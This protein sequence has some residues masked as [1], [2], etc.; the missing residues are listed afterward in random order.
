MN[1]FLVSG[2]LEQLCVVPGVI[3]ASN[4]EMENK[5]TV[6]V[7]KCAW[8]RQVARRQGLRALDRDV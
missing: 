7:N 8:K 6:A 2:S 1:K 3:N 4:F 5:N